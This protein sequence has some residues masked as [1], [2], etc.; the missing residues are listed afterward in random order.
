[1]KRRAAVLVAG[2]I[3][4][5][6][7]GVSIT[8]AGYSVGQEVS[9]RTI[10]ANSAVARGESWLS[11][12]GYGLASSYITYAFNITASAVF[13]A[14]VIEGPYEFPSSPLQRDPLRQGFAFPNIFPSPTPP[15]VTV[16]M[17]ITLPA[18]ASY[19]YGDDVEAYFLAANSDLGTGEGVLYNGDYNIYLSGA[20]F[21]ILGSVGT[22]S[23]NVSM[24][25]SAVGSLFPG[26]DTPQDLSN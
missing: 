15:I 10:E 14:A 1:M 19:L 23:W 5:L 21:I 22:G 8:V 9:A 26:L 4:A 17:L 25:M 20:D 18:N 16:S 2:I 11:M 7:L 13:P 12:K 3:F 24:G 6:A